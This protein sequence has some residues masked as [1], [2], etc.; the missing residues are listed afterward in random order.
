MLADGDRE[1]GQFPVVQQDS[2]IS[3]QG[4][5]RVGRMVRVPGQAGSGF[6]RGGKRLSGGNGVSNGAKCRAFFNFNKN[7][8][9]EEDFR[10]GLSTMC[11]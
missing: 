9:Q 10:C 11:L 2:M 8:D 4:A 7:K 6:A 1:K 5:S 3:V